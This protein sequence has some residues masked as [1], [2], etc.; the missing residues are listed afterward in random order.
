M[1][2]N[3]QDV[4]MNQTQHYPCEEPCEELEP[5]PMTRKRRV[6]EQK[7]R[8]LPAQKIRILEERVAALI[9]DKEKVQY[10]ATATKIFLQE[11]RSRATEKYDKAR[12]EMVC[13][14]QNNN[15]MIRKA[16]EFINMLTG[17]VDQTQAENKAL[18]YR[19]QT[20]ESTPSYGLQNTRTT[21]PMKLSLVGSNKD[22]M[23][24][25]SSAAI[26]NNKKGVEELPFVVL[27]RGGTN[28]LTFCPGS[29][30]PLEI[31]AIAMEIITEYYIIN[32]PAKGQCINRHLQGDMCIDATDGGMYVACR[33]CTN[34]RRP[35]I[36]DI[37]NRLA[38]VPLHRRVR[39]A[40]RVNDTGYFIRLGGP[41][42]VKGLWKNESKKRDMQEAET[43]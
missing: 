1:A 8:D 20:L 25:D 38:L 30:L 19:L 34:K 14:V 22:A 35:C 23:D 4:I 13:L 40:A 5:N 9:A 11:E 17:K 10:E 43:T 18:R 21:V 29:L 39:S 26:V 37:D 3:L 6:A 15:D 28:H 33:H 36:R 32:H 31:Q 7:A 12:A 2:D 41:L 42:M 27:E 16:S 24:M